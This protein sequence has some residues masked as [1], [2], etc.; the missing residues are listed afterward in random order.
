MS[1][2]LSRRVALLWICPMLF[3]GCGPGTPR[4][5]VIGTWE[6]G[7]PNKKRTM[8][9][10]DN[11]VWSYKS[12][13]LKYTGQYKFIADDKVEIKVDVPSGAKPITFTRV[14]SFSYHDKMNTTDPDSLRRTTWLRSPE[15]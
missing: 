7:L 4:E 3:M 2:R 14:L 12:G 1:I 5:A 13:D 6:S 11:G 15:S 9:F 10:W 8:T